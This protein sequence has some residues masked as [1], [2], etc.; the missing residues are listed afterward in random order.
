MEG[1]R[2]DFLKEVGALGA[3]AAMGQLTLHAADK[4]EGKQPNRVPQFQID[5]VTAAGRSLRQM[6]E[7]SPLTPKP[8]HALSS[9]P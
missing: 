7:L 5:H 3:M 8:V 4:P 2:R 1:N 6:Q 9:L